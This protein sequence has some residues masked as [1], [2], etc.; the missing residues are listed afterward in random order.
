[1]PGIRKNSG[2]FSL[3]RGGET[4]DSYQGHAFR[5]TVSAENK[6]GFQPLGFDSAPNSILRQ[7]R[8]ATQY[9]YFFSRFALNFAQ[10]A[11]WAAA[12]FRRAVA[13]RVRRDTVAN[14]PPSNLPSTARAASTWRRLFTRCA[15]SALNSATIFPNPLSLGMNELY[16]ILRHRYYSSP[17]E[18][19]TFP[20]STFV[21]FPSLWRQAMLLW[22]SFS[23]EEPVRAIR[24]TT[25]T[26]SGTFCFR[27]L[28]RSSGGLTVSIPRPCLAAR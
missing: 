28:K 24:P 13:E 17:E 5:H 7:A 22:N 12:I 23:G 10:R 1:M 19:L 27:A 15:L 26:G 11:F 3:G 2:H 9:P 8:E 6:S 16:R 14:F 21:P 25:Q 18:T 4:G 20:N